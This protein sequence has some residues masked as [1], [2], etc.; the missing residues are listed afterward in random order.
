[1]R[2]GDTYARVSAEGGTKRVQPNISLNLSL[3]FIAKYQHYDVGLRLLSTVIRYFQANNYLTQQN[4]PKMSRDIDHLSMELPSLTLSQ[5]NELF[6]MLR[7]GYLPS[8]AYRVK[9]LVFRDSGGQPIP[10]ITETVV[11]TSDIA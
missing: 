10:S 3:L 7:T 4:T 2:Q 11:R 1:M 5:Q 6:S 9:G 8:V